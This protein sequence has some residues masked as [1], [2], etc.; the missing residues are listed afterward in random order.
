MRT[1]LTLLCLALGSTLFTPHLHAADTQEEQEKVTVLDALSAV[2]KRKA[3]RRDNEV[4]GLGKITK[5]ADDIRKE[6][7]FGIRDLTRY[8][9]SIS[10]VEQGRGASSGYSMRGVDRNRVAL[11]VDGLPQIQS[12]TT[13]YSKANGGAVN[14]IEYENLRSIELSKGA[15]SAEYG[16]GALGGAVGFRSKEARDILAHGKNWGIDSKTAYSS[17]N[18]QVMQSLGIAARHQG[19]EGLLQYTIRKGKETR[20]HRDAERLQQSFTRLEAVADGYLLEKGS[21]PDQRDKGWF[22]LADECLNYE[23]S[24]CT[25]K[26]HATHTRGLTNQDVGGSQTLPARRDARTDTPLTAAEAEA[27]TKRLH[28]TETVSAKD[29]T[30]PDRIA[31]NPMDYNSRSLLLKGSYRIAPSHRIGAVV[32]QT[33]QRY[34]IR[35]MT[36]PAYHTPQ[37]YRNDIRYATGG[38]YSGNEPAAGLVI[39]KGLG[40]ARKSSLQWSRTHFF[41]ERHKKGRQGIYYEYTADKGWADNF[42]VRFDQ[43]N[44]SINSRWQQLNCSVYPTVDKNCR[45]STDKPWSFAESERNRYSERHRLLQLQW[46]KTFKLG[47]T[48]HKL[49]LLA[50]HNAFRS[51]LERGDYFAEHAQNR[52][53]DIRADT[54]YYGSYDNPF[55]Y[56]RREPVIMRRELCDASGKSKGLDDC[57]PRL[58]NGSNQFVALRNHIA[59]GRFADWGIGLRYDRHRFKSSDPWTSTGTFRNFSW[60]SGLTVRP[61]TQTALSYRISSGYRVPAFYELFGRRNPAASIDHPGHYVGKFRPEKALNQ[62]FGVGFKGAFGTLE[63]SYFHNRYKDLITEGK[64]IGVDGYDQWGYHNLQ[65]ISLGGVNFLGKIYWDGI[66]EKLPEGLYTHAAYSRIRA[67]KVSTKAGFSF[68]DSPLLDT[69]QPDRY[70]LGIGYDHPEGKWGFN[71]TFTY[72]AAKNNRDLVGT[73][74]YANGKALALKGTR[75]RSKRWYTH[76]LSGYYR[77]KERFTLRAGVYNLT[78]R[79]YSTWESVRQSSINAVNPDGGTRNHASYAAPGRNYTL[80]LEAKF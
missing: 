19:W 30:G 14:E 61:T 21:T 25:P 32:E 3:T 13:R 42:T 55:V 40:G 37:D 50:G 15:S 78:N 65:N 18:R 59:F 22:I 54:R 1:R 4:T 11:L 48:T 10:V 66:S 49:N 68:T 16:N 53:E 31:P 17:K 73:E 76:D 72:S 35:D 74:Y 20:I 33:A 24:P 5:N 64:P 52:F 26:Y 47:K 77:L 79:K 58:I 38:A 6:Q 2:G 56:R 80:S 69:L 63:A 36:V 45:V 60:N 8:D 7:I 43:Q 75:H 67:K 39:D 23:T 29:Y 51:K 71:H 27:Y 9:P 57:S 46:G 44:I 34:D 12:Y 62:E 41:D 70:I 28:P